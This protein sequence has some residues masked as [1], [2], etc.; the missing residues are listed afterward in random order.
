MQELAD[1]IAKT[2]LEIVAKQE[3]RWSEN[4]VIKINNY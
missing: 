2:K 3:T 1:Q 4:G